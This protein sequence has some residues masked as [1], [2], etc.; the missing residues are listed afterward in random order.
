MAISYS[1]VKLPE[2]I[3]Q[4]RQW[5]QVGFFDG[6]RWSDSSHEA[7]KFHW[8]IHEA[9]NL[10]PWQLRT[11]GKIT[12]FPYVFLQI[13]RL[14][15][16]PSHIRSLQRCRRVSPSPWA[17]KRRPR[18][19][20]S[21]RWWTPNWS[22]ARGPGW[23]ALGIVWSC[24]NMCWNHPYIDKGHKNIQKPLSITVLEFFLGVWVNI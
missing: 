10:R 19:H 11:L 14:P 12:S 24:W 8:R 3:N 22:I 15:C 20:S 13:L 17:A 4:G 6:S 18:P 9:P 1:Y 21:S 2:G 7:S 23:W 5:P 16:F